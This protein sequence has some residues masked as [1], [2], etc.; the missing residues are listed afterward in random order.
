MR[1]AVIA[2]VVALLIGGC[3][4]QPKNAFEAGKPYPTFESALSASVHAAYS[5]GQISKSDFPDSSTRDTAIACYVS[6]VA[7]G[8]PNNDKAVMLRAM[9]SGQWDPEATALMDKWAPTGPD[10]A[11][12]DKAR[13][14]GN[15]AKI[16]PDIAA[17]YPG[18]FD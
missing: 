14:Q 13:L 18:S 5:S 12:D 6:S 17:R 9:N 15:A 11:A 8:V 4:S 10:A 2:G 3:A 16:C 1:I 7:M